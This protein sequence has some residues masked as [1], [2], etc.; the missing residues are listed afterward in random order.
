MVAGPTLR[1]LQAAFAAALI[2]N[3][4]VP[5]DVQGGTVTAAV[6][7]SVHS[8]TVRASLRNAI[9]ATFPVTRALMEPRTFDDIAGRFISAHPPDKGWLCAYGA[10]FPEFVAGLPPTTV[11]PHLADVA[12]L[13]WLCVAAANAP[14]T[15]RLDLSTLA[16]LS[17]DQLAVVR[18]RLR[19]SAF[20]LRSDH[21]VLAIWTAGR[22]E[23]GAFASAEPDTGSSPLLI[24]Q[25]QTMV[26]VTAL[27]VGEGAFTGAT[28]NGQSLLEAAAAGVVDPSFNLASTLVRLCSVG[29]LSAVLD[30]DDS[31]SKP[32]LL[33]RH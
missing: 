19:E 18:L 23:A 22:N 32:Q 10:A 26:T 17:A 7:F 8:N 21:P 13:E 15:P 25:A 6:R 2:G 31:Q 27:S 12:Q 30:Q 20:L 3:S 11:P 1:E 5:Y 24:S 16:R 9:A 28:E 4:R 29:A 33:G 14:D